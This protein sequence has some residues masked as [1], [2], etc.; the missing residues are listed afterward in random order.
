[1]K[2]CIAVFAVAVALVAT[3]FG[4]NDYV[5]IAGRIEGTN[6]FSA[7]A[8]SGLNSVGNF[9]TAVGNN[10]FRESQQNDGVA[11]G[12]MAFASAKEGDLNTMVGVFA[13]YGSTN[14]HGCVGIGA[15]AFMGANAQTNSTS[16]NG[17]F[18]AQG[19]KNRFWITPD[20][21]HS[22]NWDGCPPIYYDNGTLYL[23]ARAIVKREGVVEKTA[24]LYA[25]SWV[26]AMDNSIFVASYG[27]DEYDGS[28]MYYPK[29]TIQGALTALTNDT[30]TIYLDGGVYESP[31]YL[32]RII[33]T[34][35]RRVTIVG[36]GKPEDTIIDCGGVRKL[37]GGA[38]G[39]FVHFANVTLK[40]AC[41]PKAGSTTE[42]RG[43]IQLA[44]L[45]NCKIVGSMTLSNSYWPFYGVVFDNCL[46]DITVS[47]VGTPSANPGHAG[48]SWY[49]M[50]SNC[51][52]Y[53]T[54]AKVKKGVYGE[55]YPNFA[56]R[57][58]AENCHFDVGGEVYYSN[59]TAGS[60]IGLGDRG[61]MIDSTLAISNVIDLAYS[62][63]S[64]NSADFTNLVFAVGST[65]PVNAKASFCT[66][67]DDFKSRISPD[68]LRPYLN[69]FDMLPF[70]YGSAYDRSVRDGATIAVMNILEA[71]GSLSAAQSAALA[72]AKP[73]LQ[74]RNA[75]RV[76]EDGKARRERFGNIVVDAL[77][78]GN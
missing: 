2:K 17:Q 52:L 8:Y 22:A 57:I 23:N 18:V 10:S 30:T 60:P 28:S 25:A 37:N 7:A 58:R 27:D 33:T 66:S 9:T 71:S 39:N 59:L 56:Y 24:P 31:E 41:V 47:T 48:S 45:H 64:A 4:A 19:D 46:V 38:S 12:A 54:V 6:S 69:D 13:G 36:V 62:T 32:N 51:H 78:V 3:C 34:L 55:A 65:T 68:T 44:Y 75:T 74:A 49:V 70:G 43:A 29:R 61:A 73:M 50:W 35:E 20:K 42:N 63:G 15:G 1:M 40:D 26:D 21:M 76:I 11:I 16:I 77:V 53:D 72:S 67:Y 14:L 5:N